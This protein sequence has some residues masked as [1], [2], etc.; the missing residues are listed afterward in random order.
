MSS[1]LEQ[2]KEL[3]KNK[4]YKKALN[5]AKKKTRKTIK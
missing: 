2:A 3:I 1:K 5:I 4:E